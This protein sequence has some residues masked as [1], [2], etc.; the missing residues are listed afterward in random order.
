M[1]PPL[2]ARRP[3]APTDS[4]AP[5]ELHAR[6][7]RML[8]ERLA[9]DGLVTE[10]LDADTPL[11]ERLSLDSVDAI[12]IVVGL[13]R[14]F[15]IVIGSDFADRDAFRSIRSLGELV[16]RRLAAGEGSAP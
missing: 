2:P 13:E 12:E 6:I 5:T 9:L 3:P 4:V 16:S 7:R 8:V 15:G 1:S 14:E 11:A 10:D